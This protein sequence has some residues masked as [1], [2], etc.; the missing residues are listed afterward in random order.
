LARGRL[1]AFITAG[2]CRGRSHKSRWG[3]MPYK[4][5]S[6]RTAGGAAVREADI[7]EIVVV[8]VMDRWEGASCRQTP[9]RYDS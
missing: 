3:G 7:L 1:R 4:R 8:E 5:E 6:R 2:G 9:V